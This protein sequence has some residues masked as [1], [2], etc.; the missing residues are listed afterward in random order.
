MSWNQ[1]LHGSINFRCGGIDSIVVSLDLGLRSLR[2]VKIRADREEEN[3]SKDN[4]D[5]DNENHFY[6]RKAFFIL[7]NLFHVH[8]LLKVSSEFIAIL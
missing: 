7:L 3:G 6:E 8:I 4:D 1:K 5:G 2:L